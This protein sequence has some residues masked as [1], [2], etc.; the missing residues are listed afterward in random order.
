MTS[1]PNELKATGER[2]VPIAGNASDS[3]IITG[4]GN[5]VFP[6]GADAVSALTPTRLHEVPPPPADSTGREDELKELLA[7]IEVGGVTISGLQ[8]L[9]G[10]GKTVLALKLVEML[11]P[12]YPDAQFYLDLKG[13]SA[14]P[15][16]TAEALAHVVRAYHPTA[17]LPDSESELQALFIDRE[18]GDRRGEG[19][20]LWN[21][22]LALDELGERFQA[23]QHAEQALAIREQIE[24]PRAAKVR[25]QLASWREQSNP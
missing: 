15:L 13:S 23:I 18:I 3:I 5:V 22:S 10:I 2:A 25:E 8:G 21:M 11:K 4:D 7:A 19:T 9:G 14:Q 20:A 16:T 12:R 1:D 24:D 17:K 6:K